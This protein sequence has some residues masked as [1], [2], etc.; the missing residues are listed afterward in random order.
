MSEKL[1]GWKELPIGGTIPEPGSSLKYET[2]NWRALRPV[3]VRPEK[4]I[5]CLLCWIHC[6]EGTIKRKE[7]DTVEVNYVYCKGCGICA[8]VCPTKVFEMVPES[9][10]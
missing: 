9:E 10:V 7:D 4:C 1:K 3:M 8:E 6:P 5:K 2:G